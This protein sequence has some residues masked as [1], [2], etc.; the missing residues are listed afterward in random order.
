MKTKAKRKRALKRLAKLKLP[1]GLRALVR[2]D[3]RPRAESKCL[4]KQYGKPLRRVS[5]SVASTPYFY[6]AA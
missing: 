5:L 1:L 2:G 3:G 4:L 6:F